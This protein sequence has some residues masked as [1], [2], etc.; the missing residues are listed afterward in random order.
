MEFGKTKGHAN[1]F[2]VLESAWRVPDWQ[3]MK[4]ALAQVWVRVCY[5]IFTCWTDRMSRGKPGTRKKLG[6][7]NNTFVLIQTHLDK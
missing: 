5:G 1:P 7:C 3:P 2:L 4:E 6:D